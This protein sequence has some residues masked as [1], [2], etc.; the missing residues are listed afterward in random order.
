MKVRFTPEIVILFVLTLALAACNTNSPFRQK[1]HVYKT[2]LTGIRLGDGVP[3]NLDVFLRWK[4]E[5][6]NTFFTQF[7][8]VDSFSRLV[9]Y[10]RAMELSGTVAYRF[11]SVDSVF[12]GQ[13]ELFLADVKNV[14]RSKLGEKGI[15]VKEVAISRLGFPESY[16]AAMEA[17]GMKRQ[18][19]EGIRNQNEVDLEQAIASKKKADADAQVA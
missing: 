6:P 12:A 5:D 14:L 11:A 7:P 13:R 1:D 18:H 2:T 15:T 3:L 16:T 10:P 4:I 8:N 17:V 9:L 19:I